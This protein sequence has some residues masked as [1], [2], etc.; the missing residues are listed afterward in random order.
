MLCTRVRLG[1]LIR[2]IRLIRHA[3]LLIAGRKYPSSGTLQLQLNHIYCGHEI[4]IK[5]NVGHC[6]FQQA[7]DTISVYVMLTFL[8]IS[9]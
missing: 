3:R 7:A 2:L 6:R 4:D 5:W 1:T 8:T 9:A